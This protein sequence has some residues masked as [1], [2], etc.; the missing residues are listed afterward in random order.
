MNIIFKA[1]SGFLAIVLLVS[2]DGCMTYSAAQ[3][4]KGRHDKAHWIG[5]SS[6]DHDDTNHPSYYLLMPLTV[7]ADV[8]T[9]PLQL[10]FWIPY[11]WLGGLGNNC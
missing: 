5:Q 2:L 9:A 3:E 6:F 1:L 8:A 4:A 11:F 7:P 10:F